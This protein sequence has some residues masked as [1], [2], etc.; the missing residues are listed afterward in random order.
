MTLDYGI[1]GIF[2]IMG[3]A[4]F[5]SSTVGRYQV[6]VGCLA[7]DCRT[8]AVAALVSATLTSVCL[9]AWKAYMGVSENSGYLIWGP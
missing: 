5:I 6:W 4:G 9:R 8:P 7:S 2:L 1:Y 3:N